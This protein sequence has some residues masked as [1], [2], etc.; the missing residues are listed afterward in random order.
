MSSCPLGSSLHTAVE[1]PQVVRAGVEKASMQSTLVSCSASLKLIVVS[2]LC[3]LA[4]LL[5]LL[6][7]RK[8][9]MLFSPLETV[10]LLNV[11][12]NAQKHWNSV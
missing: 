12:V 3:W 8:C 7:T 1:L 2:V 9:G 11:K 4:P 10:L 6:V 5:V